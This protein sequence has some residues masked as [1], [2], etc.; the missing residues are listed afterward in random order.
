MHDGE[1]RI[2]H[3]AS[4]SRDHWIDLPDSAAPE[5]GRKVL[6]KRLNVGGGGPATGKGNGALVYELRDE[7]SGE[8]LAVY[9]E[10]EE[11]KADLLERGKLVMSP[12]LQVGEK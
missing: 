9:D 7:R 2:M 10:S 12:E 6:W 1:E 11:G 5:T 3:I 8:T 4:R